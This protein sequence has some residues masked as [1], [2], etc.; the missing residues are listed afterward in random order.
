MPPWTLSKSILG[1]VVG[2]TAPP[3][4]APASTLILH[5]FPMTATT[6]LLR[7]LPAVPP[8]THN[9]VDPKVMRS[10]APIAIATVQTHTG[11]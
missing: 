1:L 11:S 3:S 4:L 10:V 7:Q 8:W 9:P 5:E 6:H 2:D